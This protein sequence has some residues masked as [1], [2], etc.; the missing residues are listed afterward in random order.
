MMLFPAACSVAM[1]RIATRIVAAA[2][3]RRVF[4]HAG[5]AAW[6]QYVTL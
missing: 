3:R 2:L 6:L 1:A 4:L 5:G